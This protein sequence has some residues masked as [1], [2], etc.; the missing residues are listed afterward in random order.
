M[1][2]GWETE[3]KQRFAKISS[4]GG[5][6]FCVKVR[7]EFLM[8]FCGGLPL[9]HGDAGLLQGDPKGISGHP[10]GERSDQSS[11][12]SS[13]SMPLLP[14]FALTLKSRIQNYRRGR[15]RWTTVQKTPS[16]CGRPM[17]LQQT[18]NPRISAARKLRSAVFIL[19]TR[20]GRPR[21]VKGF[22]GQPVRDNQ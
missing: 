14:N 12:I 8:W 17:D 3:I 22:Q 7:P 21:E 18:Q 15:I 16:E 20:K 9:G 11:H 6:S 13:V 5:F 2:S 10:T 1:P 19:Q 4:N